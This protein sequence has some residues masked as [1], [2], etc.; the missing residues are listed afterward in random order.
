VTDEDGYRLWLRYQ[1][2]ADPDRL[3]EARALCA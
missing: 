3:A 2:I 1:P